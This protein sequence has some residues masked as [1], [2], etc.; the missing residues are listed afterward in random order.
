MVDLSSRAASFTC[1]ADEHCPHPGQRITARFSFPQYG[2]DNSFEMADF[3]RSGH[4]CR[5]DQVNGHLRRIAIQ[6][7][8][9]L[10]LRPGEQLTEESQ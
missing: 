10:P 6:F 2:P 1:Y 5:V 4:V 8:E 9:P 7:A 3:T